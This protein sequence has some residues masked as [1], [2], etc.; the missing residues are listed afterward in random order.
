MLFINIS[1]ITVWLIHVGERKKA[2][3]DYFLII[4]SLI[5]TERTVLLHMLYVK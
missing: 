3:D 5:N 4:K 2:T 1:L